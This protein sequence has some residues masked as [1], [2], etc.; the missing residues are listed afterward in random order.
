MPL[1]RK[2]VPLSKF[3]Y[4]LNSNEIDIEDSTEEGKK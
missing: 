4:P 1:S 2:K 3:T